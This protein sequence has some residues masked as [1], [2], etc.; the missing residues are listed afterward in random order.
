MIK[1]YFG[2]G[3][4]V[5]V[6]SLFTLQAK[7]SLDSKF[8]IITFHPAVDGGDYF[9]V[10]GSQNLKAWQG[11]V[12]LYIDYSNRPLQFI[13]VGNATGRQSII[14]HMLVGDLY[15]AIGLTDWAEVGVNIPVVFYNWFFTDNFAAE[16]DH[17]GGMGDI[18]LMTKFRVINTENHKVG[19]SI[20]PFVTLPSGDPV[21]FTGNANPTGGVLFIT[22]FII[23]ERFTL[24][25]NLGG[26]I[27]D[28][29]TV[30]D[31]RIDDQ[32]KYGLAGNIRLGKNWFAIIE[33]Y[34]TTPFR[35]LFSNEGE[36]PLEAGGG[37]RYMFGDSGFSMNLGGTAGLVDGVGAPRARGFLG[38]NW[39]SPI[40]EKDCPVCAPP[41]PP[42]DPRI[43]G[44]KIVIWG[45]IYFD[46][47]KADIKP[48]SYPVLDDV[49]DVMNKNS[50]IE[51]V[52]VQGNCD[53]R[54]SDAYN[55]KLSDRRANSVLEYLVSKGI[56]ASR[57]QS[58]GFG[59]HNPIADNKTK[60]GMSQ[61]R[62]V[63]FVIQKDSS[64]L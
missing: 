13:G 44:G 5:L 41:A 49:V 31:V 12:G 46:T 19:F 35:S 20:M 25:L 40:R 26:V 22:D 1:K 51:L 24:A 15:G 9:S 43:K 32:F 61:N 59:W 34:G 11:N 28:D 47:D 3:F 52:E 62:R 56:S 27:R 16:E 55:M 14:D 17:G 23:H 18:Q 50:Q 63:E 10:Y 45:K 21:R 60:E 6:F 8:D 39:T 2:F 30:H 29:V 64:Q 7:A 53:I 54:G 38:V 4:M 37:I 42:P 33:T 58:K 57:L 48:I 36:S